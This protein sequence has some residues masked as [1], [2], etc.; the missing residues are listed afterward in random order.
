[1]RALLVVPRLPGTGFTGDRVRASIHLDALREAGFSVVAVGGLPP[2]APLPELPGVERVVGV[3]IKRSSALLRLGLAAL[4]GDPLQ[5]AEPAG[6]WNDAL[7]SVAGPFDLVVASLVRLWPH[8][9]GRLPAAP[10]VF[11]YIDALGEAARQAASDDPA[12]WR[13]LYWK[14]DAPRLLRAEADVAAFAAARAATTAFDAAHLPGGTVAIP[15]G[16]E[17]GP[18]PSFDAR[19]PVVAFSGRLVYRPNELAVKRLVERIW[20][21]VKRDVPEAELRIG[22]ADAGAA[23]RGLDGGNG[24]RVV[25]PVPSMPE[26]LRAARVVAAPV[27]LGTGTPNKV[28]EAFEAGCAVVASPQA[29]ERAASGGAPAPARIAGSDAAFAESL[30]ALLRANRGAAEEGARGRAFV[31]AHAD[32][33]RSVEQFA[34]LFRSAAEAK[35]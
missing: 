6:D 10:L 2:G 14:A 24:V 27:T 20:P 4:T 13:R 17:I 35:G 15:N 31:E 5:S 7:A 32:R 16:V 22:G 25:S 19:G 33:R 26:F 30:V 21:L 34:A 8:L 12:L 28:F 3:E 9:R 18:A 1:M 11:D 23:L 29:A